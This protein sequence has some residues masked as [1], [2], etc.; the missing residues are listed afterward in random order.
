MSSPNSP[1]STARSTSGSNV[2]SDNVGGGDV[3][4]LFALWEE[5]RPQLVF[6]LDRSGE[7]GYVLLSHA[8]HPVQAL[9]A[10]GGDAGDHQHRRGSAEP[11]PAGQGMG[12]TAGP[13][14]NQAA[15]GSDRGQD[16]GGVG[17]RFHDAAAWLAA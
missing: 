17:S 9:Y 7:L 3:L 13:A 10:I 2:W 5:V 11:G 14:S 15:L 16:G 4:E 8:G 1:V 12:T 6:A